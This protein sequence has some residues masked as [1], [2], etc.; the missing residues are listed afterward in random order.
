M[1]ETA[2]PTTV[3]A[4]EGE[5]ADWGPL[6]SLPGNPMMWILILGE[7]A[8]FGAMF[9]G[10]AVARAL[11]PTTFD[12]S[13]AQLDRLLGGVNTMVLVTSGWLVAVAVRRRAAGLS[14]RPLMLG[15]M[16]LGGLFLAIKAVEY[17]DK[18]GRDLTLET[19]SFFQ[20]Y[21]LLT[22]FHAMHVAAGI[23]ILGIVTRWD[24]LENLE[25]GAAFWHM[26]DLIWVLLY[27]IVYLL[28]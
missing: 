18:I 15:A 20:L 8:A 21:Y 26:V 24:S 14:H 10:F 11:D 17:G 13:Q 4:S 3:V 25:T 9:L 16:A 23:V 2:A 5:V 19:N 27:P 22:G 12:A 6:S 7:L 28:R 1:T